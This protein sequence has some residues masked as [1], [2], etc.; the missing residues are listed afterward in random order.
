MTVLNGAALC[1]RNFENRNLLFDLPFLCVVEPKGL[2]KSA[3]MGHKLSAYVT[4][5]DTSPSLDAMPTFEPMYGF[6]DGRKERGKR[7]LKLPKFQSYLPSFRILL[8]S[9]SG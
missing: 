6:T 5:P 9:V 7:N 4:S 8:R 1:K 3:K 2:R